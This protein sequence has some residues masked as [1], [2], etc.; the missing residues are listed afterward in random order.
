MRGQPS[1]PVSG[2]QAQASRP[3]VAQA[4]PVSTASEDTVPTTGRSPSQSAPPAVDTAVT[5]TTGRSADR[6]GYGGPPVVHRDD[7]VRPRPDAPPSAPPAAARSIKPL[8]APLP[9]VNSILVAPDRRLAVLNGEI[10]REGAAV[11]PRVLVRIEPGAVVLREPSGYEV[12][13]P[14]RRKLS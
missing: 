13:V 3:T 10:V 12:R 2:L 7:A 1:R 5:A 11:G 9:E 6:P 4:A 14:I 8:S